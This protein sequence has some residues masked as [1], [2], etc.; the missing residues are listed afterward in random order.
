MKNI[1][2]VIAIVVIFG[3]KGSQS[4]APPIDQVEMEKTGSTHTSQNS[5]DWDGIYRGILPCADCEGIQ[6]TIYLRKDLSFTTKTKYLGKSDTVYESSGKFGW[7]EKGNTILLIPSEKGQ[8]AQ[9]LVGE[10]ILTQLDMQSKKITGKNAAGYILTKSNYGI[11]EKYWKLVELN[12]RPVAVDSTFVKEPHIIF[13]ESDNRM[14]GNGGCNNISGSVRIEGL[15][16]IA[17]SKTI[18]TKMACPRMELEQEFLDVLQIAD[19]FN[20]NGDMLLLNKARMAPLARFKT[21]YMR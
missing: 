7:N 21:V 5:L 4:S 12:G 18:S 13:K 19:N 14:N 17:I 11:L 1:I 10:N 20:V 9:Y 3:C 15:N 6:T 8:G 2:T 16:R